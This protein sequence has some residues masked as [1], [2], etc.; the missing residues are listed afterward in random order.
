MSLNIS[1]IVPF[2]KTMTL[3][4]TGRLSTIYW[5]IYALFDTTASVF[6]AILKAILGA[7]LAVMRHSLSLCLQECRLLVFPLKQFSKIPLQYTFPP[8]IGK[9]T[10]I[11]HYG[12]HFGSHG[13]HFA[14]FDNLALLNYAQSFLLFNS[15]AKHLGANI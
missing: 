12:S 7:I 2:T 1:A 14:K 13:R 10:V 8:F 11:L 6:A 5:Q 4:L 3:V 15:T 9:H